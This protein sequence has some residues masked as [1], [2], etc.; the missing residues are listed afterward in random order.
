MPARRT[1]EEHERWVSIA[2]AKG[3]EWVSRTFAAKD[4]SIVGMG[5]SLVPASLRLPRSDRPKVR[6]EA[7][8]DSFTDPP[9]A[10]VPDESELGQP[11]AAAPAASSVSDESFRLRVD[12]E[13]P[14]RVGG[15]ACKVASLKGAE[16]GGA[17][18]VEAREVEDGL[19]P[20]GFVSNSGN[21]RSASSGVSRLA[22]LDARLRELLLSDAGKGGGAGTALC[23]LSMVR[24]D[25]RL[26]LLRPIKDPNGELDRDGGRGCSSAP[27]K[28]DSL[29]VG[30]RSLLNR[31]PSAFEPRDPLEGVAGP[32]DMVPYGLRAVSD[33]E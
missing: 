29:A 10:F 18:E 3:G 13:V 2:F 9:E 15:R 1:A 25:A 14:G 19:S 11:D 17:P 7:P 12:M 22:Y 5:S 21:D 33:E 8:S 23:W 16:S 31:R 26:L 24:T 6:L 4:P 27:C 30:V 20:K 28:G 32:L